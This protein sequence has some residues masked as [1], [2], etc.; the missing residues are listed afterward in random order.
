MYLYC[1]STN[2]QTRVL[3]QSPW[4]LNLSNLS[5][6]KLT[7]WFNWIPGTLTTA[8]KILQLLY[9]RWMAMIFKKKKDT[10]D[11]ILREKVKSQKSKWRKALGPVLISWMGPSISSIACWGHVQDANGHRRWVVGRRA[12]W[13][14]HWGTSHQRHILVPV[15]RLTDMVGLCVSPGKYRQPVP[16]Y[17]L[18]PSGRQQQ[19]LVHWNAT[20]AFN[21]SRVNLLDWLSQL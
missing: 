5:V 13:A 10:V 12:V 15:L 16:T 6:I 17:R 14:L 3:T 11:D 2:N 4:E 9:R 21:R 20:L 7:T 1:H 18:P 8:A 19:L